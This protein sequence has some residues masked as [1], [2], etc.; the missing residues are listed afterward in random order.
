MS[1]R[2]YNYVTNASVFVAI[3][4]A[5]L[6]ERAGKLTWVLGSLG[7]VAGIAA[8]VAYFCNQFR[9]EPANGE[10]SQRNEA[11]SEVTSSQAA[12]QTQY[13]ALNSELVGTKTGQIGGNYVVDGAVI[14]STMF[15]V[16]EYVETDPFVDQITQIVNKLCSAENGPSYEFVLRRDGSFVIR[17]SR[18]H[19]WTSAERISDAETE[20]LPASPTV[21]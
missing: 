6:F 11:K 2:L 10:P 12:I 16:R 17:E 18:P 9:Q 15:R 1:S 20:F 8:A 7:I 14:V 5:L 13:S 21:H 3:I 4:S 19:D